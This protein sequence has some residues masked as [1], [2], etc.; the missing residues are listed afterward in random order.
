MAALCKFLQPLSFR[1]G[2]LPANFPILSLLPA[3]F[4]V[5]EA[6]QVQV[7]DF[8]GD[9]ECMSSHPGLHSG[10]PTSDGVPVH[11]PGSSRP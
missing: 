2:L 11:Q 3:R 10:R 1:G 4:S 5:T 7:E 8:E 9:G 6:S